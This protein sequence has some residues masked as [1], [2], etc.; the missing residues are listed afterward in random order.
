MCIKETIQI[1]WCCFVNVLVF[2]LLTAWTSSQG[3][4]SLSW[5][6]IDF[7]FVNRQR[8]YK[9]AGL[10]QPEEG[11]LP[12]ELLLY[13]QHLHSLSCFKRY[14]HKQ[15]WTED[16]Y[17]ELSQKE[18]K[19]SLQSLQLLPAGKRPPHTPRSSGRT[20]TTTFFFSSPK[21]SQFFT[22]LQAHPLDHNIP[23]WAH[24]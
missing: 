10:F 24:I 5:R 12:R 21:F 20:Q 23:I 4:N 11:S 15:L 9:Q 16:A 2:W 3:N 22:Y 7:S 14:T 13:C 1:G 8:C 6:N 19:Y 18:L 17:T